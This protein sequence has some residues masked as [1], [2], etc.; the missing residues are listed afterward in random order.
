[1]TDLPT[2]T[3]T[4]LFTDIEG[5][6]PLWDS[7]PAAMRVALS[8]H[9]EILRS[10]IAARAGY[11]FSTGGDGL[12]AVFSRADDAVGAA[13]AAQLAF[14]AE[15]W[16]DE[17][18]LR[19]RMGVH[20]GEVEERD[21]DYFGP[22]VNRAARLMGSCSGGQLVISALTAELL[23]GTDDIELVDLGSVQLKGLV[24][25]VHVFGVSADGFGWVDRP[26]VTAQTTAGNLPRLQTEWFGDLANLQS[27]V[28]RLAQA[29]LVTLT[30]SGGVGKTRAA[31]EIGWLVVDEFTDGVWFVE[32][33]PIADPEAVNEAVASTLSI[34]PEAGLSIVESI[35][36]WCLGRRMLLIIDN[37]EHVLDPV[38][39]LVSAVVAECPT[40]T[41]VAT[42]REPLGLA[43][44]Q[45][46]RIPSLGRD[47]GVE[48]FMSRA[49]AADGSFTPTQAD[50][51]VVAA[52]CA[53]V[54]GIALAIELAA[55]RIRS[56]SPADL[57][58]RLD[59]RFRLLRGGGRGGLERHQ[60]L[61]AA[62]TWSYQLLS[63]VDRLL[64][65]RLS[66]FAGGF[67]AEAA[68]AVCGGDDI[69]EEEVI[70]VLSGL[71]DK[72]MV[73]AERVG[74]TTRYRLLETLRQY[75]EERLD[76]RQTT[77]ELRD[78]HLRYYDGLA[79]ET[80][81]RYLG[82]GQ[83]E[84]DDVF[85]HEWNNLRAA[86]G[87]AMTVEDIAASESLV[88]STLWHAGGKLRHE[89]AEW[90]SRT[91]HLGQHNEVCS[92]S[93]YAAA[94]MWAMH[95]ADPERM[96]QLAHRG[97]ELRPND[98]NIEMCHAFVVYGLMMSGQTDEATAA[99]PGLLH[100]L[101]SE[102]PLIVQVLLLHAV[103]DALIAQPSGDTHLARLR[104][105]AQRLGQPAS[106]ADV[107]RKKG[108]ALLWS[109]DPPDFEGA[110]AAY[111]ESLL[112]A[113]VT[114]AKAAEC[115]AQFGLAAVAVL[116][117]WPDAAIH[118]REALTRGYESRNWASVTAVLETCTSHFRRTDA[119]QQAA[120]ILGQLELRPPAFAPAVD[121]RR[122]SVEALEATP[123]A[124]EYA[125]NGAA[126]DRHQI[127]AYALTQLDNH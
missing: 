13:V 56:L 67:D 88:N 83:L 47:D 23:D 92:A 39:E 44:E 74:P 48:L 6:T 19:V 36:D 53:R 4:F 114:R 7:H 18:E 35:V 28:S 63:D 81:E 45:V 76:E 112:L 68:E 34:Q 80:N 126:M 11:V 31:L 14:G 41:I 78:R 106:L 94:A 22:P 12:A 119:P 105:T 2:G 120:T 107:E 118:L 42:S 125:A 5:S 96:L 25:P 29:R 32:L 124:A 85:D 62:V 51:D 113:D 15:P 100:L 122:E 65:D 72:S 66:V 38:M 93:T 52:V 103:N 55:A 59:N 86:H 90:T 111:R 57:L 71:V 101:E 79:Q 116:G 115:W 87:W 109:T 82:P 27:R 84:A 110:E 1:M 46:E 102:P 69:D 64:F 49:V 9:D 17:A 33:G 104:S 16:P 73:I 89:H 50:V 37:C 97:I 91:M 77:S 43:G 8:R 127:V 117:S 58:D 21:G 61:R 95:A 30:G 108:N 3:V 123:N 60:T 40:V 75:G 70:D 24:D 20:T 99:A 54:D 98:P 26:L 121:M 10:A